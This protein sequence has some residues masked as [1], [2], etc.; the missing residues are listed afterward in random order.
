[1]KQL[2]IICG[3]LLATLFASSQNIQRTSNGNYIAV[4]QSKNDS[5]TNV[6]TGKTYTDAAGEV[7]K[8][9]RSVHGK[10]FI[11]RVSKKSG[12]TY[13]KYLTIEN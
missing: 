12:L 11:Y 13:K 10:Y 1:M 2:I 5:A 4:K 9:F 3:L 7:F 6:N 8:I